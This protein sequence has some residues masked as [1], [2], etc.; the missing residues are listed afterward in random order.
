MIRLEL[1]VDDIA[2]IMAKGYTVIR[3]YTDTDPAGGFASLDGTVT[4]VE[5]T[6]GYMYVD[7]DGDTATYYKAAF[8]GT[9]PGE[10]AKSAVQQGGTMDA[11][12]TASDVRQELA[13]GSGI[14][15]V[16]AK[17]DYSL[18][19]MA[20]EASRLIDAQRGL[21]NN[22]YLATGAASARVLDG[23]GQV[24]LRLPW[25]AVS[26][27]TVEVEETDGTYTEWAATDYFTWP[28]NTLTNQPIWR[29]DVNRKSSGTK[30]VW[31]RGQDR[32]RVTAVWGV[33]AT[34]PALIERACKMQTAIWYKMAMSGW[35]DTGGAVDFG[36]LRYPRK[37][38]P[39][40]A[41]LA[42]QAPPNWARL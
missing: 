4:L 31:T 1:A 27:S 12:C 8:Y 25:P 38:D 42:R 21:E 23:N 14:S 15:N 35:S 26:V 37:I 13:I 36:E 3:V 7:T 16:G 19:K 5:H 28:R 33:S 30:Q 32:V 6:T 2:N 20:I 10:S 29:L 9:S 24:S 34:V 40:V 41:H 22:A 18:W 39:A 17:W 11:Y